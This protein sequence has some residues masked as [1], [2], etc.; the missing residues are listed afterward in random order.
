MNGAF[1]GLAAVTPGSGFMSPRAACLVGLAGGCVSYGWCAHIKPRLGIDDA[2]DVCALQGMPG[3]V[4]SLAVGLVAAPP[5]APHVGLLHGGGGAL[6]S[7]QA[8]ALACAVSWA[9]GWTWLLM[10][11]MRRTVGI[12]TTVDEEEQG[13]DIVQIGEQAY[14][15]TLPLLLDLGSQVLTAKLCDACRDGNL[16]KVQQLVKEGAPPTAADYDLRTPLHLA[17]SEGW[18]EIASWLITYHRADVNCSDR[19]GNTP[20]S[21]AIRRNHTKLAGWLK[22][23]GALESTFG[24]DGDMIRAAAD[25]NTE[26]VRW[27]IESAARRR[28]GGA[29]VGKDDPDSVTAANYDY[30]TPLH[31]AACEGHVEVVRLL[32]ENGA[33]PEARDRWKRTAYQEAKRMGYEG[34]AKLIEYKWAAMPPSLGQRGRQLG[35]AVLQNDDG[36]PAPRLGG[37]QG[38]GKRLPTSMA[39]LTAPLMGTDPP[40]TRRSRPQSFGHHPA[41]SAGA[42]L[43]IES[44]A[45]GDVASVSQS[46]AKGVDPNVGD[47]DGRTAL[48]VAATLGQMRVVEALLRSPTALVD[49][50]DRWGKTPLQDASENGHDS[51]GCGDVPP[52]ARRHRQ[53]RKGGE[54]ALHGGSCGQHR[55]PGAAPGRGERYQRVG[56]RRADRTPSRRLG[57][58]RP[59]CSLAT[60]ARRQRQSP[61]SVRRLASGRLISRGPAATRCAKSSNK[62][63]RTPLAALPSPV[64]HHSSRLKR[65]QW[66]VQPR[67]RCHRSCRPRMSHRPSPSVRPH[68]MSNSC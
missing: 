5:Y 15:D 56:L 9:F 66:S 19:F 29:I 41:F 18:L 25:G 46:L 4:G 37:R 24:I 3:I 49:V 28:H 60:V 39:A 14:D 63:R 50:F 30:R 43:L 16:P 26:E 47:Y 42:R 40:E 21:D 58:A 6:L 31:V 44:A 54:A 55:P 11:V 38:R 64:L 57:R 10:H 61:R 68:V 48:H 36:A 20:L 1:A 13:L 51:R 45:L 62:A 59:G 7:A 32:L 22:A 67:H 27:R 65:P 34:C 35:N 33:R 23:H 53:E 2:L 12:D 52:G 17:A 8:V